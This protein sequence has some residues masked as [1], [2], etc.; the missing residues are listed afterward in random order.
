MVKLYSFLTEALEGVRGSGSSPGRS[1]SPR[2]TRYP[3]YRSLGLPQVRPEQVR[4]ILP[5]RDSIPGPSSPFTVTLPT[6]LPGPQIYDCCTGNIN[7]SPIGFALF[8]AFTP[9]IPNG[10]CSFAIRTLRLAS[11]SYFFLVFEFRFSFPY[12]L[13]ANLTTFQ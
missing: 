6:E 3:L 11:G 10:F 12:W 4:K 13:P 2:N 7:S 5:H 1:L 9:P 8:I